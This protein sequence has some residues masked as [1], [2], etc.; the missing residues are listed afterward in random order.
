M[1]TSPNNK[2]QSTVN[3]PF[4]YLTILYSISFQDGLP[5]E[6]SNSPSAV[7]ITIDDTDIAQD[8]ADFSITNTPITVSWII[9]SYI[10][11]RLVGL[12]IFGQ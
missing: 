8:V 6:S 11:M 10:F 1:N 3:V 2:S 5:N 7:A 9:F 12:G 4:K